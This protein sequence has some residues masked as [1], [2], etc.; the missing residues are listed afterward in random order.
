[1]SAFHPLRTLVSL[2]IAVAQKTQ[3]TTNRL[4]IVERVAPLT[5]RFVPLKP[6][7]GGVVA[8]IRSS[9]ASTQNTARERLG[10]AFERVWPV[11]ET[12]LFSGLVRAIDDADRELRRRRKGQG[13]C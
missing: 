8:E 3:P 9:S 2:G 6:A 10:H 4:R 5:R 1:M 11:Q 12:S 13:D 7:S